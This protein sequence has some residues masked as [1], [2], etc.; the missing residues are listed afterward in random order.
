MPVIIIGAMLIAPLSGPLA[1]LGAGTATVDRSLIRLSAINFALIS[2]CGFFISFIFFLLTPGP[3]QE[4]WFTRTA[5]AI[6]DV[7]VSVIC[8]MI[9]A[10]SGH[11]RRNGFVIAGVAVSTVLLPPLCTAGLYAASARA[12]MAW[13]A[14]S[15]YLVNAVF[16]SAGCFAMIRL[17]KFRKIPS[18]QKAGQFRVVMIIFAL[19]AVYF[20]CLMAWKEIFKARVREFVDKEISSKNL[21]VVSRSANA[22]KREV[23]L[24]LY[25][26][27]MDD[28]TLSRITTNKRFYGLQ[29]ASITVRYLPE[30][31]ITDSIKKWTLGMKREYNDEAV[32][33]NTNDLVSR[34]LKKRL[35]EYDFARIEPE[36]YNEFTA[37]FGECREL[38]IE[39]GMIHGE[40]GKRDTCVLIYMRQPPGA[41]KINVRQVE[42]WMKAR[43]NINEVRLISK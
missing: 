2:V 13:G 26:A 11:G 5:P 37:L 19:A 15:L 24:V 8:G 30:E 43:L 7:L 34:Q 28:S 33:L 31:G 22:A 16:I 12:G 21:Y 25:G 23:A 39:R 38:A 10:L 27:V 20:I 14:F 1:G 42:K 3:V 41:V 6:W 17:S 9:V 4:G 29:D 35:A 40:N 32:S 18:D 36:V